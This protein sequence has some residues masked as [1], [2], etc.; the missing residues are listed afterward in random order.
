MRCASSCR[1]PLNPSGPIVETVWD[2][3]L[4]NQ[5]DV[6]QARLTYK[7][8]STDKSQATLLVR[9][10]NTDEPTTIPADKW[11]FIDAQTVRLLP[12]G[13]AF[14]IGDIYQLI[15]KAANPPVTGIG[16]AATRDIVSF[17]RYATADDAGTPNPLVAAGRPA[18]NARSRRATRKAA[19]TCVI[20]FTADSM[21]TRRI[22]PSSTARFR[23]WRR[24][25]RS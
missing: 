4:F 11:E 6:K 8:T 22:A 17:A 24:G 25:G 2:E 19:A 5:A 20:S 14:K 13:T 3:L 15:Y 21:R 16:F 1:S 10:R 12:A 18:L 23:R 9:A 7:A